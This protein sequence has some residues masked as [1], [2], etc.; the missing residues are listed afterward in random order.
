VNSSSNISTDP[1]LGPRQVAAM[2]RLFSSSVIREM[3]RKGRSPLFARIARETNLL[4]SISKCDLV[5]SLFDKAFSLLKREGLRDE[6]IYKAAL[7]DR[8]LLGTHSLRTACMLNE[9]RVGECKADIVILNGTAT[10]YEVKSERDSLQRLDRQVTAYLKV[11]A[12]VYV[13]AAEDHVPA[14]RGIV[15]QD[16]GILCLSPNDRIRTI[17]EAIERPERTC[18]VAVFESLRTQEAKMLL[19]S[20]GVT[21][22]N[23]PNTMLHSTLGSLFA[24]LKP[25][26]AHQGMVKVLRKTRNLVSLSTLVS[27]LP[28]SLQMAALSV[29]LRKADHARLVDAVHTRLGVAMHWS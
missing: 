20:Q 29:P 16:V 13:I 14:V 7:T 2:S 28:R 21:I 5:H 12:R 18:P 1:D 23:V 26:D 15:P 4:D 22:P 3:A 25:L 10:V 19:I 8:I 6:Y 24:K 9:F 11:F 27:Q 17:R